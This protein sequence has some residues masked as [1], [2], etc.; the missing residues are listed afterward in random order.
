MRRGGFPF[1]SATLVAALGALLAA[2]LGGGCGGGPAVPRVVLLV[3]IDTCRADPLGCYGGSVATPTLDGLAEDG[4]LFLRAGAPAPITLPSHLS[5]LTG[6]YPDRHTVRDNGE[7]PLPP[8]AETIAETLRAAG[9]STGAFLS[10]APLH[11]SFGADQGFDR[12]DDDFL[13][14]PDGGN[15][16]ARL[17][18]D[19]RVA[20][21]VTSLALAWIREASAG[22]A[23][24]FAWVH[25]F[26]PHS[27]YTPPAP[28]ATGDPLAD[29]GGEI[30]YVDRELARLIGAVGD[31]ALIVVVGDHGESLGQ[32]DEL[33]HGFFTYEATLRVPWIVRGAGVPAGRRVETPVSIVDVTPTILDLLGIAAPAGLDGASA[34][35]LFA[36][37]SG[38]AGPVFAEALFPRLHF[39][40]AGLRSVRHGKWKLIEA[41]EPELY[42]LAEDPDELRNLAA[43]HPDLVEDLAALLHEHAGR[44]GALPV[45]DPGGIDAAM[46]ERLEGLG[47]LGAANAASSSD[48]DDLFDPSRRNPRDMIGVF[49]E[50]ERLPQVVLGGTRDESD[51][52]VTDLLAKDPGNVELLRSVAKL[53]LRAGHL[54]AALRRGREILSIE[55]GDVD[56]W[57]LVANT[58]LAAGD[59]AAAITSVRGALE[60]DPADVAGHLRLAALLEARGRVSEAVVEY[61]AALA[62][63][64]G[65]RDAVLGKAIALSGAGRKRDAVRV[66]REH[67]DALPDDVDVRNNLAWLLA[68]ERIDPA[69]ALTHARRARTLAPDDAAVLDTFGWAAIRSGHAAEAIEPLTRALEMT[70]D[71][72]VRA[73]L[74]IALTETGRADEGDA[75]IRAAVKERPSLRTVP[76][77]AERL[78]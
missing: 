21:D 73:H 77:V 49:R 68:N 29:Y 52:F 37:E 12:Y 66:L 58:Q 71:A 16:M 2:P 50:L 64:P 75:M 25:Y 48:E 57:R 42:D 53:R 31:D 19:Q 11:G 24:C 3:T 62:L 72:E 28:F 63:S 61:D 55:P 59:S 15:V 41:P 47:Y 38:D 9:W 65:L 8:E 30:A 35:P 20:G 76:E 7:G 70:G 13:S 22:G 1:R 74:G 10:A 54:D 78:R 32:H 18:H 27:P 39:G 14:V 56:A 6:L 67:V 5:I 45:A 36:G 4:A 46:K 33:T 34:R 40:W 51:A 17:D 69:E 26:D 44:G 43:E 60:R 23:P